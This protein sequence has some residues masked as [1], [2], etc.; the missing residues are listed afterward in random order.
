MISI[1]ELKSV[2]LKNLNKDKD[3]DIWGHL[4]FIEFQEISI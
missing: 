1:N 4:K 3:V 2:L